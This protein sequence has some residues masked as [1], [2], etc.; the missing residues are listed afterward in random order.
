[1]KALS[2]FVAENLATRLHRA[3]ILRCRA[4]R[5]CQMSMTPGPSFYFRGIHNSPPWSHS[6][7]KMVGISRQ[8]E[9]IA[10]IAT[11]AKGR[12]V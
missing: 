12:S 8:G 9:L 2:V 10:Q 4:S 1:M 5:N 7:R 3:Q 11:A 6:R